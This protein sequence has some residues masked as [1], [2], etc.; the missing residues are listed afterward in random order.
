MANSMIV[1]TSDRTAAARFPAN[2]SRA[3]FFWLNDLVGT[4]IAQKYRLNGLMA[5]G[6]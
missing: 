3:A 2:S 5:I 4:E 6:P 1:D